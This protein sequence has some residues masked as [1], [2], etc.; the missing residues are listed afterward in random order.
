V[1]WVA[2]SSD[3]YAGGSKKIDREQVKCHGH[4]HVLHME[5]VKITGLY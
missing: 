2:K 4:F 3:W 1:Q 5:N